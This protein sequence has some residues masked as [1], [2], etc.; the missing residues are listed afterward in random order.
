[1]AEDKRDSFIFYRSF[2]EAIRDLP[3][4][5]KAKI[6]DAI[7]ELSLNFNELELTGISKSLFI[8][9]KPQIEANNKRFR[10][11]IKPK[12]KQNGSKTEAKKK[13]E[14][15]NIDENKSKTE[16][17]NNVNVNNNNNINDSN[18]LEYRK[19][20]FLK[21]LKPYFEQYD[22][23]MIMDFFEYWTEHG[24]R[25]KKMRFEKENTFGIGRRLA[26]WK[27]NQLKFSNGTN[28]D[29]NKTGKGNGHK[30]NIV[31]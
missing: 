17:N 6:L 30:F 28:K 3:D 8:L 24:F 31:K 2:Y 25:D 15:S 23:K 26:T 9:I 29:N 12:Q 5:E 21:S 27:N 7:C 16:A 1:M 19:S 22:K 18:K 13:Q 20:E 14:K 10:N 11:G 4:A